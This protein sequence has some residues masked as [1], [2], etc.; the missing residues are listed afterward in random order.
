MFVD[1]A[2][3]DGVIGDVGAVNVAATVINIRGGLFF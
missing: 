2:V 3:V 1:V